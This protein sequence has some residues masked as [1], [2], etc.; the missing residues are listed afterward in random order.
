MAPHEGKNQSLRRDREKKGENKRSASEASMRLERRREGVG[1]PKRRI[2]TSHSTARKRRR[3]DRPTPCYRFWGG[4]GKRN[5]IDPRP[6]RRFSVFRARKIEKLNL[7]KKREEGGKVE[8]ENPPRGYIE[9]QP[10]PKRKEKGGR[11]RARRTAARARGG[12][13]KKGKR[14]KNALASTIPHARS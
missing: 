4:K 2:S 12:G 8:N 14:G 3:G 10:R 7:E 11:S 5:K 9:V 13:G 6:R 1:R